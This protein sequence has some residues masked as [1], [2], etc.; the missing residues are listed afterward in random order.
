MDEQTDLL[1]LRDAFAYVRRVLRLVVSGACLIALFN[2]V[3]DPYD[4]VGAPRWPGINQYKHGTR[5]NSRIAKVYQVERARPVT[6]I[7]G[8]SRTEMALD[9]RH[10]AL[11]QQPAFNLSIEGATD[12]E[13][14]RLLQHA[15]AVAPV[16]E[17]F[18]GLDYYSLGQG[19]STGSGFEET[20]LAVRADGSP[21]PHRHS[22]LLPAL[23]S[24]TALNLSFKT[25]T[26]RFKH[27]SYV[28]NELGFREIR[29]NHRDVLAKGGHRRAFLEAE[30]NNV[31]NY[32]F[33]TT[34]AGIGQ[35]D[36]LEPVAG[37]LALCRQKGVRV[38]LVLFP[39]H[40]RLQEFIRAKG[41][42][43]TYLE[44]KRAL[45]LLVAEEARHTGWTAAPELW[46][47]STLSAINREEV[48]GAQDAV[49]PM[50]WYRESGHATKAMGDLML[51]RMT[52]GQPASRF[53]PHFGVRLTPEVIE[54]ELARQGAALEEWR[55]GHP[56]DVAEV[57][58]TL[59]QAGQVSVP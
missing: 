45:T 8:S 31:G 39:K 4:V 46:D 17:A 14:W 19:R 33:R 52:G 29:D 28:I 6:V 44:W 51:D 26:M 41:G 32:G 38:H 12:Y 22:D 34:D 15:L 23:F 54:V 30:A 40:A 53:P 36:P 2:A 24:A 58:E 49:T 9:P 18:I 56:D 7:I 27:P 50:R 1:P 10:P 25:L 37:M 55:R 11:V 16:K 3:I 48:P 59:R 35:P 20:R 5:E 13:L 57:A 43:K 47:F 21:T 42:W